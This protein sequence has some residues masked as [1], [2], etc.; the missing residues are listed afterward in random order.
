MGVSVQENH[1]PVAP[2][3]KFW[4]KNTKNVI[5]LRKYWLSGSCQFACTQCQRILT[6]CSIFG[7]SSPTS[8]W[9]WTPWAEKIRPHNLQIHIIYKNQRSRRFWQASSRFGLSLFFLSLL[10]WSSTASFLLLLIYLCTCGN[11]VWSLPLPFHSLT[12]KILYVRF[13]SASIIIEKVLS[14]LW[15]A[16]ESWKKLP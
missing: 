13:K 16:T 9:Q 11:L 5:E 3:A 14:Q 4:N 6:T 15:E 12:H 8:H 7:H 1:S 2:A 10:C